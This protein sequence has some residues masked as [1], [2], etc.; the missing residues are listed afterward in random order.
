MK[1]I[2][3][4]SLPSGIRSSFRVERERVK[5]EPDLEGGSKRER[6]EKTKNPRPKRAAPCAFHASEKLF[7]GSEDPS[8]ISLSVSSF[9]K[10]K[11]CADAPLHLLPLLPPMV[12]AEARERK[13]VGIFFF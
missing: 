4:W 1:R 10:I 3:R 13:E 11:K 9:K 7:F 5:R 12:V 6:G 8:S 2:A